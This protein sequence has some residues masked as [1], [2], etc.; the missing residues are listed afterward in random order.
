MR[1]DVRTFTQ[2]SGYN[3][4]ANAAAAACDQDCFIL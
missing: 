2:G 4:S 3:L 1:D